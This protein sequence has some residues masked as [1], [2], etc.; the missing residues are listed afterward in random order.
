MKFEKYKQIFAKHMV[1][2]V[3]WLLGEDGRETQYS[4]KKRQQQHKNKSH[5]ALLIRT[6]Q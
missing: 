3:L 6:S 2:S 1:F 4:T 5:T